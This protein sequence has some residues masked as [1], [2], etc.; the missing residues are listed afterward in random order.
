MNISNFSKFLLLALVLSVGATG[1]R[2]TPKSPTPIFQDHGTT[3]RGSSNPSPPETMQPT[4]PPDNGA[5]STPLPSTSG[6]TPLASRAGFENYNQD[7]DTFKQDVVHFD[8]DKYNVKPSEVSKVEAVASFLKGQP[9]DKVLVEG[10]C[11]ERGTPEYNRALGE[12]RALSVREALISQGVAADRIQTV[13][14]G[15]D[16]PVDPGH[17]E[18]AWAKNR[19]ADFVLLTPKSGAAQ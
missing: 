2:K 14:Y 16:K 3:I 9:A 7:R 8:F 6:E 1:C 15:E 18:A 10:N 12:R 4:L 19:R 13:S 5:R 11:D 17:N